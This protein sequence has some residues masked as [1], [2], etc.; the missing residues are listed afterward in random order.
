[1]KKKKKLPQEFEI[2][3]LFLVK[4]GNDYKRTFIG[5]IYRETT[6]GGKI[7][8]RGYAEVT[9]GKLWSI[10]ESDDELGKYLDDLCVM[11]LDIG[12][13]LYPGVSIKI[14][15]EDFFLN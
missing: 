4:A 12:L 13:H 5:Q 10:T 7:I 8:V 2:T 14:F 11:K 15:N 1:M 3:E 9:D 6:E